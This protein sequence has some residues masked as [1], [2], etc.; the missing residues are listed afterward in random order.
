LVCIHSLDIDS[1][2]P[3]KDR[4]IT[5]RATSI[6]EIGNSGTSTGITNSICKNE[7]TTN[8]ADILVESNSFIQL[9]ST[10]TTNGKKEER[11]IMQREQP[12]GLSLGESQFYA[13]TSHTPTNKRHGLIYQE[14]DEIYS[15]PPIEDTFHDAIDDLNINKDQVID[16]D[17]SKK[18]C[19]FFVNCIRYKSEKNEPLCRVCHCRP[20][21]HEFIHKSIN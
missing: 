11:D 1:S 7:I 9:S 13:K 12:S 19:I 6:H 16:D 2:S 15:S 8:Q 10:K 18:I 3:E 5:T 14:S 17:K 4:C 20:L 21:S